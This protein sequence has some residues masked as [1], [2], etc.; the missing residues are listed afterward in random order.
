M[1]KAFGYI[2][3]LIALASLAAGCLREIDPAMP[4]GKSPLLSVRPRVF[5]AT[6]EEIAT[7]AKDDT[8]ANIVAG[9]EV[10]ARDE[11]RENFF[12]SL[13]I[14]VKRQSDGPGTAW[15]KEYHLNAGDAGVIVDP[16][17]YDN[18][19]LLDKAK[20]ALASNWAEQ[21]Y[22]TDTPYDIY[23]TANNP[24]T[25]AGVAPANLTALRALTT[26]SNDIFRYYLTYTPS[27]EDR[28]Y[29]TN[30]MYS[31][32]KNFLMD[33]K[34]E[35]WTIDPS[36]SEQV[37]DVDL[38][39]AAAKVLL[40][41]NFSDKKTMPMISETSESNPVADTLKDANGRVVYGSLK[42]YMQYVGRS[43]GEPRIKPV[44]FSLTA[45]DVAYT[46][47]TVPA[48]ESLLVID[49]NYT[50]FKEG[51]S[52][53]NTDNTFAVVTY[54]YPV[55]WSSDGSRTPYILLSVFYTRNSDGDQLR[56]Y[57]RIPICDESTTTALERNNIYI[58]DVEIASLGSSN[59]SFEAQDEELRIE[60]HVIPWTETNMTQEATTVK[61]SDTKYLTIIPTEYILK[62]DGEQS[63][64][65]QWF[66]SVSTDDGRV[67][68]IDE[69]SLKVS[70]INYQS[71][72][73]DIKGTVTKQVRND[74]GTLVTAT[75]AN[76]DGK[77]DIVV[78]STAP[79]GST[80]K[81]EKVT[82][83]LTPNGIIKIDSDALLS[84]AIKDI[85]FNVYLRNASGVDP[86]PITIRHFP[87]DNIQSFTGLWSS[88]WDGTME[89]KEYNEYTS[90]LATA[91]GWGS[92]NTHTNPSVS[93]DEYM[94]YTG[95]KTD[96]SATTTLTNAQISTIFGVTNNN[97]RNANAYA[98]GANSLE[99]AKYYNGKYYWVTRTGNYNYTYTY[100]VAD[101]FTLT[102]TVYSRHVQATVPST[103]SWV[104]WGGHD[105]TTQQGIFTAK[106]YYNNMCY[107]ITDHDSRGSSYT[108][109]TNNHMY[110]LQITSTS[111][112]Y[113]IGRPV[114][115]SNYQSQDKVVSPAFMIASQLGA[116]N[117][118]NSDTTA[119]S[120]CGTYMEVGE[121][122][123]RFVGWRLP[124][125]QEIEVIISYQT[126][127]N[128]QNVTMVTVL[129]GQYYW[130][131]DG[132]TAYVSSGSGGST[133]TG[134]VRCVRDL[135]LEE[136]EQLNNR[137]SF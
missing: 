12:G 136:V 106:V 67:V 52:A 126:G 82:I 23:V 91:Q 132:T 81:G 117:T 90:S 31:E 135:T 35:G 71:N 19:S 21:G 76:T 119:A 98:T 123:K 86:V 29:Y 127:T 133:T 59:A 72:T 64:D 27:Q 18:E 66:A 92:Y 25:A 122:G 13:D 94:M 8:T 20:Q 108:N 56:S 114:L 51:D 41:V 80:A 107:G 4:G 84:R 16:S 78:T 103:G 93:Y 39:R 24:H 118:T 69:S 68:D 101:T 37:F 58:V 79:N 6:R 47:D 63:V 3:L 17:K 105:G 73:V 10:N 96:N 95:A 111:N 33:G 121:D 102:G 99:T 137:T 22:V 131:L 44:N 85:T 11:L 50:T 15:F 110:V 70:Y 55:D 48:T 125:K 120:H 129:G 9:D 88:R 2:L 77:R 53:D 28:I 61:V 104:E 49:G 89:N 34:I 75:A 116:V 42:E 40:T 5:N 128:T 74:G 87:L 26:T 7:K 43:A 62:G 113:V 38:K 97:Q 60:Y 45:S 115:D 30:C 112:K 134:Y 1:K 65:L 83:T 130:A 109:L 14:F 36:T 32:K 57:Y 54:T 100:H 124:T 46:G